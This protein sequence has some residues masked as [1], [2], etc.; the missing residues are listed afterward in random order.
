VPIEC[1]IVCLTERRLTRSQ[2][3]RRKSRL[4]IRA[5]APKK[6]TETIATIALI[7]QRAYQICST[8]SFPNVS[9]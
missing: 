2:G 5:T 4:Q 7:S 9:P 6:H 3:I 1:T 8:S